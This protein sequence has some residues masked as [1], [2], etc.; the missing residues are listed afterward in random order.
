VDGGGR[1]FGR[2]G[3]QLWDSGGVRFGFEQRWTASVDAVEAVYL[4]EAFWSGLTGLTKTSPPEVL[5]VSRTGGRAVVRLRYRLSVDLP[6]EAA[7]F[8]DPDDVA[9]V[10]HTEWNLAERRADMRF[11]PVQAAALM[12]ASAISTL[13]AAGGDTTRQIKGELRV[14]IPLLGGRV[15]HAVVD[16]I[17][18]HLDEE[19]DA[20]AARLIDA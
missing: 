9:W 5:E 10:E 11:E 7:R 6:R 17:G 20:V 1:S 2:G 15:E 12:K 19:A 16:G 8:I 13:S 14:R 18:E 4:D 3:R